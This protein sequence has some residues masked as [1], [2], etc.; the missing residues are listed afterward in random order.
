MYAARFEQ[1]FAG[2]LN[3]K[4]AVATTN[5][6]AALHL[7]VLAAGVKPGAE[8]I[9]PSFTFAATAECVLC[10]GAKP[11]FVDIDPNKY[12]VDPECVGKAIT[13]KT[14]AVIVVH[15]G[16]QMADMDPNIRLKGMV[17]E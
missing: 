14:K 16:G 12:N 17:P 13:P 1:E 11:V 5:G 8:V 15:Y 6:T 4:Q 3:L 7:A 10:A 2:H 9:I